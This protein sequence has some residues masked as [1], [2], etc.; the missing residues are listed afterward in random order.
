M[1]LVCTTNVSMF[2]LCTMKHLNRCV[3]GFNINEKL[4]ANGKYILEGVWPDTRGNLEESSMNH[5]VGDQVKL[6]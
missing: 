1:A 5:S 6:N 2:S 3:I 4:D